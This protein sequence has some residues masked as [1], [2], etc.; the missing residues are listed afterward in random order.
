LPRQ[1]VRNLVTE[2]NYFNGLLTGSESPTRHEGPYAGAHELHADPDQEKTHQTTEG[3]HSLLADHSGYQLRGAQSQPDHKASQ[4]N[5]GHTGHRPAV[6]QRLQRASLELCN[7]GRNFDYHRNDIN[8]GLVKGPRIFTAGKAIASTGGHA[9]PTNGFRVDLMGDPGPK[10]GVINNAK[11][12]RKAVRQRY[13]DGVD[14]IKITATGD[15]LSVAASG[16]AP[17]FTEKEIRTIV[18]T[19][20]E[21]GY[22]VAVHAHG[23]EGISAR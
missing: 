13:K 15:V 9:D 23:A 20:K 2:R 17:Q 3:F 11:D 8:A 7:F 1:F 19:A 22:R 10:E 4:H 5:T 14:L 18:E 16:Q 12:A 21:Y 6:G